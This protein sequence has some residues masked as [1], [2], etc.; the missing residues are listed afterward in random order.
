MIARH[1]AAI[2]ALENER[3][4][5]KDM[6]AVSEKNVVSLWAKNE[7]LADQLIAAAPN[8]E[9]NG[10]LE[11]ITARRDAE[12][13]FRELNAATARADVAAV[14]AWDAQELAKKR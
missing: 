9:A 13:R 7:A 12:Q 2:I 5:W 1:V 4:E 10:L 11:A 8:I 6:Y 3:D 14:D